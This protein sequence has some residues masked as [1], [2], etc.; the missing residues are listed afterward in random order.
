MFPVCIWFPGPGLYA[1]PTLRLSKDVSSFEPSEAW[2]R[3]SKSWSEVLTVAE[4]DPD[5]RV[6]ADSVC[7]ISVWLISGFPAG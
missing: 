4:T 7:V 6:T 5:L 2:N 3:M 1:K